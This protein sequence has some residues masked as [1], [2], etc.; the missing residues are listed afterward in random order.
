MLYGDSTVVVWDVGR[1]PMTT[2][3]YAHLLALL[4]LWHVNLTTFSNPEKYE[5]SSFIV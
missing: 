4:F 5:W 3:P 1:H 2:I